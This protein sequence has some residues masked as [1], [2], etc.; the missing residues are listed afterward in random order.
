MRNVPKNKV[1]GGFALLV[2][3]VILSI[4]LF[5][6]ASAGN[7]TVSQVRVT[8]CGDGVMEGAEQCDTGKHCANSTVCTADATCAG[9]GD[10]LCSLR[11][12]GNCTPT[13]TIVSGG[14]RPPVTQVTI[15]D[16]TARPEQRYSGNGNNYD[17]DF[18]FS[19]LNADNLNHTTLF[20]Q[21]TPFSSNSSGTASPYLILPDSIVAGAYD[22]LIKPRAHLALIQ[23]NVYLQAGD[24]SVNFTNPD[25]GPTIGSTVLFA[26]D[27]DGAG[28]SRNSFGDNV[29]NSID[30]SALL[31]QIGSF[32][33]SGNGF[34][35]NLNQDSAV[36]QGDLNILLGNLDREGDR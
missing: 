18:Y 9:I 7:V 14:S 34:R 22:V 5:Q 21:P 4:S 33:P 1:W 12:F 6:F 16:I 25:N 8:V 19:V 35:A 32:D 15:T 31:G 20:Q 29:I 36:D 28:N 17:T 26:G 11:S 13:C 27:I 30:L 24:N 3:G 10:G 23:N 2:S